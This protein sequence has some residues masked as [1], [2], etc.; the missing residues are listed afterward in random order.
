MLPA[1]ESAAPKERDDRR[2]FRIL[3]FSMQST[4]TLVTAQ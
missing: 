1:E 4:V 3:H 2:A